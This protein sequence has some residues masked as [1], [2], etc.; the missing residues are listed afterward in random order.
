[1]VRTMAFDWYRNTRKPDLD[2]LVAY[3]RTLKPATP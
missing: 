3:L 2:M 1:L